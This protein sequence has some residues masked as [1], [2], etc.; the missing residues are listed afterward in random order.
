MSNNYASNK[1]VAT[2]PPNPIMGFDSNLIPQKLNPW[3]L[4]SS[5]VATQ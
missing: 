5:R 4:Y 3:W 2:H 1:L